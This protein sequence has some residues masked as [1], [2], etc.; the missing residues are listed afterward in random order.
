MRQEETPLSSQES[1]VSS[2]S[3]ASFPTSK[4]SAKRR[5][6]QED[7]DTSC[8]DI[9]EDKENVSSIAAWASIFARPKA[10]AVSRRKRWVGAREADVM[11]WTTENGEFE[12]A[13]FLV[14]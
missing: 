11:D 14:P 10:K 5:L 12:E 1:N 3:A 8:L 4:A 9:D 13:N 6:D 7:G 2:V